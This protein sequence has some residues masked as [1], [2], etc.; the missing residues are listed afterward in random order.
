MAR[1]SG[2]RVLPSIKSRIFI[3]VLS[4]PKRSLVASLLGMTILVG[5]SLQPVFLAFFEEGLATDAEGFSGAADLVMRRFAPGAAARTFSGKS[6]G[7][8][9]PP[10]A[11]TA[12]V[13]GREKTTA[14][15]RALRSS[16]T[17]PGQE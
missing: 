6:A 9:K 2:R 7:S 17:L 14:R 16:R 8:S 12:P 3:T 5:W 4:H 13:P 10:F 1:S 15:S 11:A